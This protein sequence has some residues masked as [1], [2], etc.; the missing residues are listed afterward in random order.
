ML[1][2]RATLKASTLRSRSIDYKSQL[3]AAFHQ[4]CLAHFVSGRLRAVVDKIYPARAISEAHLRMEANDNA[5]K[6]VCYW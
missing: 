3:I 1:A 2:K 5:G 4:D 6:L